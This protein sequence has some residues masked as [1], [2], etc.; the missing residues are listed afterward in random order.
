MSVVGIVMVFRYIMQLHQQQ[1]QQQQLTWSDSVSDFEPD[2]QMK[3]ATSH[4]SILAR[5]ET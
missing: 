1:Q 5:F 3:R 2:E 4:H